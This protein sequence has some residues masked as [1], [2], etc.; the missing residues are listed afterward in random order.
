MLS[1]KEMDNLASVEIEIS[2]RVTAEEFEATAKKLEAFIARHG[3]V[4]VLEIIHDFEGMD[5]SAFWSDFKFSL[6]HLKDFSR[7]AIVSDTKWF[8][9]LSALAEPFIDCEVAYFQPEDLEAAR[10]WLFWPDDVTEQI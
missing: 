4:Q 2:D 3:R 10:N 5:A 6:R 9:P 8:S 1:Y 7:C